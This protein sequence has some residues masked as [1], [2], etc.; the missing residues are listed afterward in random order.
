MS[1]DIVRDRGRHGTPGYGVSALDA[2]M[3]VGKVVMFHSSE[4]WRHMTEVKFH[5]ST[6]MVAS[7]VIFL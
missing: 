3:L 5:P 6:I 1:M 7:R 2:G 4:I